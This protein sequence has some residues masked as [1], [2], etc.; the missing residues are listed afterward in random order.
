MQ[1]TFLPPPKLW[2]IHTPCSI[3]ILYRG[4]LIPKIQFLLT[5]SPELSLALALRVQ[6]AAVAVER[7]GA[8]AEVI[9][10]HVSA[11]PR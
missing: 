11:L 1:A 4:P 6:L 9:L 7:E 10:R 8:R 3:D 5:L 2:G